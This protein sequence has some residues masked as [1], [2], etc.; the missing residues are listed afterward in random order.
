MGLGSAL[1]GMSK[2]ISDPGNNFVK[3]EYFGG[4]GGYDLYSKVVKAELSLSENP[5]RKGS[6]QFIVE[7]EPVEGAK[8]PAKKTNR[9]L[10]IFLRLDE[11]DEQKAQFVIADALSIVASV[12]GQSV[13]DLLA[14]MACEPTWDKDDEEAQGEVIARYIEAACEKMQGCYMYHCDGDKRRT[15]YVPVEHV[16]IGAELPK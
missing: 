10:T 1:A 16:F 7:V 9:N 11:P 15:G 2:K 3:S 8:V 13:P 14:D 5:K 4:E 6:P 12:R